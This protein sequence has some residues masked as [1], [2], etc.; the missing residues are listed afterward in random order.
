MLRGMWKWQKRVLPFTVLVAL[1]FTVG[2]V[3]AGDP[4]PDGEVPPDAPV[5]EEGGYE[6]TDSS[7]LT[8]FHTELAP[9]GAW[10]EDPVYGVVWIPSTQVVGPDFVPYLSSGHWG[11]TAEG[12]WLW[13]SDYEWGWVVFHYGRWVWIPDRGWAWIP[14]RVYAPA[15]VV[16]RVGEPGYDY[17]GWAP[18]PPTY[19]WHGGVAVSFWVVPP[20]Y[21]VYCESRYVFVHHVHH[22]RLHGHHAREAARY[23]A[24]YKPARPSRSPGRHAAR[25]GR[26]PSLEE[27]R[28]PA[29]A[30]PRSAATPHPKAAAHA[31][32]PARATRPPQG[33]SALN[34]VSQPTYRGQPSRNAPIERR[35]VP[36]A[37][38]AARNT[39]PLPAPLRSSRTLGT[40][41]SPSTRATTGGTGFESQSPRPPNSRPSVAPSRAPT[42]QPVYRPPS[43]TRPNYSPSQSPTPS[44]PVYRAPSR[45]FD[46]PSQTRPTHS[47]SRPTYSPRPT[48]GAPSSGGYNQGSNNNGRKSSGRGRGRGV[49]SRR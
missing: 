12:D 40:N 30:A 26:G 9:H 32:A 10:V 3:H 47:A 33:R 24:P 5:V 6:D 1:W 42:P 31:N 35:A 7:A 2:L 14:G 4:A 29:D 45:S 43:S 21:Y 27:A 48:Q 25:P 36:L 13:V 46:A 39:D 49:R 18:M 37:T 16:W 44:R 20:P 23:T 38:R 15:W 28:I 22:H 34:G 8:V 41:H 19:Y 11:Y 17:V